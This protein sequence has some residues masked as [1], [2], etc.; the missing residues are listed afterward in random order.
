MCP[1]YMVTKE[2][3]HSTRGRAHLLFEML[4]GQVI[5]K[6]G[7]KDE[8]VKEALD[9]C[10]SCKGC[11]VECPMNVD[12][13]T[14]KSEFLS[15]YYEDRLRPRSAYAF[16]LIM[17]WARI[18]THLP[19]FANFF[20]QTRGLSSI[21]K[22]TAGIAPERTI[23]PFALQNFKKWFFKRKKGLNTKGKRVI[24]WADTF[25]NYF[26]PQVAQAATEVLEKLGF[27]VIVPKKSLCC[28]RPLY[29]YG[30]LDLAK[31]FLQRIMKELHEEIGEGTP[32]VA[33][34]PSCASVFRDELGNLFPGDINAKRL[35]NQVLVL[36][37]FIQKHAKE[38][39]FPKIKKKAL[40]QGHCHHKTVLKFD[41]EKEL[42]KRLGVEANI[43]DS[44]CC[45]MAGGFGFEKEHYDVS[46]KSC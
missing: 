5:G 31:K 29:D 3:K 42:L 43:L 40:V 35:K 12:M 36:S 19:R 20:T 28:G 15:H 23:P 13:A 41:A 33:L 45:G 21:A 17:R 16:G 10:L 44:G 30:M 6:D 9:L 32:I 25:N 46:Y 37:E 18:A 24:L 34:E 39:P 26:H 1:S 22:W 4:Q 14:Y 2:E 7:W 27:R 38:Y 11:K 8:S